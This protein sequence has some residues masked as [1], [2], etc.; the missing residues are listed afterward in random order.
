MLRMDLNKVDEKNS[1]KKNYDPSAAGIFQMLSFSE[2]APYG[3]IASTI[4]LALIIAY[5]C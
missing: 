3:S 5:T 2:L 1:Y 4:T